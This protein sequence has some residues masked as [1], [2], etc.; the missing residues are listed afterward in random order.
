MLLSVNKK[1]VNCILIL[2]RHKALMPSVYQGQYQVSSVRLK[3]DNRSQVLFVIVKHKVRNRSWERSSMRTNVLRRKPR[4]VLAVWQ[5]HFSAKQASTFIAQLLI[6][7]NY[8]TQTRPQVTTYCQAK[9]CTFTFAKSKRECT[10]RAQGSTALLPRKLRRNF[11]SQLSIGTQ[12][13]TSQSCHWQSYGEI[14]GD[15]QQCPPNSC[16]QLKVAFML[17]VAAKD[18]GQQ[19]VHLAALSFSPTVQCIFLSV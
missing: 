5:Q 14:D 13:L 19:K 18:Q 1:G 8:F 9:S 4:V 15:D 6:C 16:V 7:Q 10:V 3:T 12:S 2:S 11:S 17:S